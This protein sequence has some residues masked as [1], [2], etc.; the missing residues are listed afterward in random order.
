M[1]KP[2]RTELALTAFLVIVTLAL[3]WCTILQVRE[4]LS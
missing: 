3:A 2:D 4:A 1:Q